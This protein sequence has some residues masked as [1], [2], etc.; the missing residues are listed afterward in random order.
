[1]FIGSVVRGAR[2][3]RDGVRSTAYCRAHPTD[4]SRPH[5]RARRTFLNGEKGGARAGMP[6]H[7]PAHARVHVRCQRRAQHSIC[8]VAVRRQRALLVHPSVLS[9]APPPPPL[10]CPR[11][12]FV[13]QCLRG[14]EWVPRVPRA[15]SVCAL[16]RVFWRSGERA[17]MSLGVR[18]CSSRPHG[19]STPIGNDY[20]CVSSRP[21]CPR[22]SGVA[23]C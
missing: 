6:T 7:M 4:G 17:C 1:M 10:Q 23:P 2:R 11:R 18:G 21:C 16:G 12:T 19:S 15:C 5:S 8:A 20:T 22:R 14:S 9:S 13:S 3:A